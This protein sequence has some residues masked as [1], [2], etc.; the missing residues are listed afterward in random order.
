MN[1]AYIFSVITFERSHT[2]DC[3]AGAILNKHLVYL[4]VCQEGM[5]IFHQ[6]IAEPQLAEKKGHY[7]QALLPQQINSTSVVQVH[8][9]LVPAHDFFLAFLFFSY[10]AKSISD[11]SCI[12][13]LG[14]LGMLASKKLHCA[15]FL[16]HS[17][18]SLLTPEWGTK[19]HDC[20]F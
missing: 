15:V 17:F 19:L 4:S 8:I 14:V 2:F 9:T 5:G 11:H 1:V 16:S 3:L 18:A 10:E 6:S 12:I 20:F 7:K 13:T